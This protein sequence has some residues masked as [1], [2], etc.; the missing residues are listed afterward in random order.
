MGYYLVYIAQDSM[1]SACAEDL[2][3]SR[4]FNDMAAAETYYEKEEKDNAPDCMQLIRCEFI[5]GTLTPTAELRR[6]GYLARTFALRIP[7]QN[8]KE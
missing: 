5:N 2:S 7:L 1:D 3:E 6:C 8:G 4:V